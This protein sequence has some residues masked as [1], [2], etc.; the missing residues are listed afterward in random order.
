MSTKKRRVEKSSGD[1]SLRLKWSL[2]ALAHE[3]E[4]EREKGQM[5]PIIKKKKK[6][7]T[8]RETATKKKRSSSIFS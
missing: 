2:T 4:R 8:S 3:Y 7:I 1:L 6:N 5:T